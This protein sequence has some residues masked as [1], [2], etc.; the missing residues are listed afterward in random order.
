MNNKGNI[1]LPITYDQLT[2]GYEFPP[3]SY[4]LGS[5]VVSKYLE[6]ADN[7]EQKYVETNTQQDTVLIIIGVAAVVIVLIITLVMIKRK[8]NPILDQQIKT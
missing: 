1:S 5:S 7:E 4:E 3:A 2:V 6:Q 8:Q